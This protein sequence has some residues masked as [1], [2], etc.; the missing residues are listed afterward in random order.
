V[1]RDKTPE[2]LQKD[3]KKGKEDDGKQTERK[4]SPVGLK[5]LW[6]RGKKSEQDK[7]AICEA[8]KERDDK[9]QCIPA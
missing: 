2:L 8:R 3:D 5:G 6:F 4:N 1:A 7:D 9:K